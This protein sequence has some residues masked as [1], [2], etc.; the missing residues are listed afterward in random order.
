ML[1]KRLVELAWNSPG[2]GLGR[3]IGVV[4]AKVNPSG[5]PETP[6]RLRVEY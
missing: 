2:V 6:G 1:V 3:F 5:P 4:N